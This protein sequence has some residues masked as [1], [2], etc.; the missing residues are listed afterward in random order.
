MRVSFLLKLHLIVGVSQG[1]FNGSMHAC[2]CLFGIHSA[3]SDKMHELILLA[4][5]SKLSF[6]MGCQSKVDA[7]SRSTS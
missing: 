4:Y 5:M 7:F 2:F 6:S 3:V 1:G